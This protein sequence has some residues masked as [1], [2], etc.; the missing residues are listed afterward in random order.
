MKQNYLIF[1]YIFFLFFSFS[2]ICRTHAE[3]SDFPRNS[4][5]YELGGTGWS[6][7]S[8]NYERIL[9]LSEKVKFA[10]GIGFATSHLSYV[11][12]TVSI[13][14]AQLFMPVQLNFLFGKSRHLFELGY[15]MPLAFKDKA[16]GL[17]GN[18]YALRL[19]YRFQPLK[20]GLLFRISFTPGFASIIPVPMGGISLGYSF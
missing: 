14:N 18:I 19:G 17:V 11:G 16:F 8:L 7:I 3:Q 2:F 13:K 10:P 9:P 1:N 15:G 6:E 4:V 20:K 5:Y 12:G